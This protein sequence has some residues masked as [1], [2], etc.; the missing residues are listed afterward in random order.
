MPSLKSSVGSKG[1]NLH[2]GAGGKAEDDF[3]YSAQDE[4]YGALRSSWISRLRLPPLPL[5][6]A[7]RPPP[8]PAAAAPYSL[9][10]AADPPCTTSSG[11][12]VLRHKHTIST[13]ESCTLTSISNLNS[14]FTVPRYLNYIPKKP[15]SRLPPTLPRAPVVTGFGPFQVRTGRALSRR[16]EGNPGGDGGETEALGKRDYGKDGNFALFRRKAHLG[17]ERR[18]E[19]VDGERGKIGF[20]KG[21]Q[22]KPLNYEEIWDRNTS[23]LPQKRVPD[24]PNAVR[25]SPIFQFQPRLHPGYLNDSRVSGHGD[26]A[27]DTG[28]FVPPQG[29]VDS[30]FVDNYP[31]S[32]SQKLSQTRPASN[33]N[34]C[35]PLAKSYFPPRDLINESASPSQRAYD[36]HLSVDPWLASSSVQCVA[37]SR[38]VV[39]HDGTDDTAPSRTFW[40]PHILHHNTAP[41]HLERHAPAHMSEPEEPFS[42]W[43]MGRSKRKNTVSSVSPTIA[44]TSNLSGKQ[45]P[46]INFLPSKSRKLSCED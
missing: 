17:E 46:N 16:A 20:C 39:Y 34:M 37:R 5:Q 2:L 4:R 28:L 41:R 45:N 30:H 9:P 24:G 3:F 27:R 10:A 7:S 14:A 15:A 13:D 18:G 22:K 32:S 33:E 21:R 44:S 26:M 11:G 19:E 8:T 6:P 42:F 36:Q 43:N 35:S 31:T 23:F 12:G 40:E 1:G 25:L 38:G 29:E